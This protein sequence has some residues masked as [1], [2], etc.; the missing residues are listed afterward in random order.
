MHEFNAAG[1]VIRLFRRVNF[2]GQ[3]QHTEM[4]DTPAFRAGE[5]VKASR[6]QVR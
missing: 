2:A 5:D 1:P 6:I 4:Q 3:P